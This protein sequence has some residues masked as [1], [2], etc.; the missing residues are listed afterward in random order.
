MA[1][2]LPGS[3]FPYVDMF[4][5]TLPGVMKTELNMTLLVV[6]T[7]LPATSHLCQGS[8]NKHKLQFGARH[9]FVVQD[10]SRIHLLWQET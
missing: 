5:V 2:R 1:A 10:T 7:T 6:Q 8:H 4:C 3:V 9:K